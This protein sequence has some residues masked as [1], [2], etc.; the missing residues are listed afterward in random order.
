MS[1]YEIYTQSSF[2]VIESTYYTRS[3]SDIVVRVQTILS[4]V[5]RVQYVPSITKK[6]AKKAA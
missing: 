3:T 4:F 6:K 2:L 5:L 1:L